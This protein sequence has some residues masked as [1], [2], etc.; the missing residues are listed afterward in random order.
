MAA[1]VAMAVA[2]KGTEKRV[3]VAATDITE[4]RATA[5]Q[6]VIQM[7]LLLLNR[8]KHIMP[9][10]RHMVRRQSPRP[11]GALVGYPVVEMDTAAT[12][13]VAVVVV[14]VLFS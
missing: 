7:V 11:P 3:A 13:P 2:V 5:A 12:R 14:I 10:R 1:A 8:G 9:L 6:E 4:L